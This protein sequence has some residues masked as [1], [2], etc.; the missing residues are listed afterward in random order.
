MVKRIG[1]PS[2][3]IFKN[4]I[5]DKNVKFL[6]QANFDVLLSRC[7]GRMVDNSFEYS[8]VLLVN[9]CTGEFYEIKRDY[10]SPQKN[11]CNVDL[12]ICEVFNTN[13]TDSSKSIELFRTFKVG[14]QYVSLSHCL[15]YLIQQSISQYNSD[16]G[17]SSSEDSCGFYP[18]VGSY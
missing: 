18:L 6:Q 5:V 9:V 2:V 14:F 15:Q 7:R 13:P 17:L 10:E 1:I 11:I 8:F 12:T 4:P 3:M 16:S